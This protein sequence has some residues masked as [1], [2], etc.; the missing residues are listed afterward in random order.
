MFIHTM[1]VSIPVWRRYG[2]TGV[3]QI[4]GVASAAPANAIPTNQIAAQPGIDF[5][6]ATGLTLG[7]GV[8]TGYFNIS[9]SDN[10]FVSPPKVFSFTLNSV[11]R[12]NEAGTF[13]SP[14]LSTLNVTALVT[15]LDDEFGAGQFQIS[16]LTASVDEGSV[17]SFTVRRS[18]GSTGGVSVRVSTVQSGSA[19]EGVDYQPV[20]QELSF[21]DGETERSV[22]LTI[23]E[24][25]TPEIEEDLSLTLSNPSGGVALVDPQAVS[26][27]KTILVAYI[28]V[29]YWVIG[30]NLLCVFYCIFSGHCLSQSLLTTIPEEQSPS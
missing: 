21:R 15:I 8:T 1:Q 2:S 29:T 19:V 22:G 20:D 18:Q 11:T 6:A 23:I 24:D 17:F 26:N 16:P 5:S 3:I 25:N 7:D 27:H 30:T 28:S 9:L 10:A 12:A 14:R 13:T 4:T